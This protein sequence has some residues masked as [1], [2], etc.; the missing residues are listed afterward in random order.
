MGTSIVREERVRLLEEL[1]SSLEERLGEA[2]SKHDFMVVNLI[3]DRMVKIENEISVLQGG[4][5]SAQH[6]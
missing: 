1:L 6:A 2:R 5:Y 3:M 4:K